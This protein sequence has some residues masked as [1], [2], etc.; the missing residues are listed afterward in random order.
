MREFSPEAVD[1]LVA[2]SY[3]G[4]V[5][6]L[7]NMVERISMLCEHEVIGVDDLPPEVRH[8]TKKWVPGADKGR[9][10][11]TLHQIVSRIEK[12]TITRML[13]LTNGNKVKA[14]RMLNI[15]R[16]TLYAKMEEYQIE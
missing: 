8:Q 12:K 16:S 10:G 14:A 11:L 6:E 13:R 3:P 4:N 9:Q 7:R 5:R 15:S 2:Y 1:Q